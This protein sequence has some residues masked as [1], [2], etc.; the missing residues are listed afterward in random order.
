MAGFR[1][2]RF[3]KSRQFENILS[4]QPFSRAGPGQRPD[5][6]LERR[7]GSVVKI[8]GG[9]FD[10]PETGA[11][12]NVS[13]SFI[14][15]NREATFVRGDGSSPDFEMVFGDPFPMMTRDAVDG[16]RFL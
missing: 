11:L 13:V 3:K 1:A 14:S 7:G 2:K 8:G 4:L 16:A 10:V 9:Q 12:E 15:C 6:V 5:G